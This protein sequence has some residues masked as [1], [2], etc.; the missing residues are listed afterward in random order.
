MEYRTKPVFTEGFKPERKNYN[1]NSH[2]SEISCLIMEPDDQSERLISEPSVMISC[3]G[4]IELYSDIR[5]Y[6][7]FSS[8]EMKFLPPGI[9]IRMH[10]PATACLLLIKIKPAQQHFFASRLS[11]LKRYKPSVKAGFH[12]LAT[13][14]AVKA[15]LSGLLPLL[16]MGMDAPRFFE[17]KTEEL[18]E[19]L[20]RFYKPK[21]L[22]AFFYPMLTCN[23]MSFNIFVHAN[24]AVFPD[25][26]Q[27]A[28]LARM[29]KSGFSARFRKE[30]GVSPSHFY[31]SYITK[32]IKKDL[33]N[34]NT[35]IKSLATKYG[36][37]NYSAFSKF[38]TKNLGQSP[39]KLRN[40]L[41]ENK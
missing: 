23:D 24:L 8:G 41:I 15:Y 12:V 40:S 5:H 22:A 29:S 18:I 25:L 28:S 27:L 36:F 32:F 37:A 7:E 3:Q 26:D 30:F 13:N 4:G 20:F 21:Q 38:C 33:Q 9:R 16:K 11:E 10:T 14:A 31:K 35:P 19:L 1:E 34:T 17:A 2:D 6:R 39:A